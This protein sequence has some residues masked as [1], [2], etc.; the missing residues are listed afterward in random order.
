LNIFFTYRSGIFDN[1][2]YKGSSRLN[3]AVNIVGY[4]TEGKDYWI[5]RNS[6]GEDW[7]EKGMLCAIILSLIKNID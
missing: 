1:N 6:W 5:V 2:N 7:G 4:G 3:H